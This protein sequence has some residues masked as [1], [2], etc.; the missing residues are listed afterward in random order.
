MKNNFLKPFNNFYS[1]HNVVVRANGAVASWQKRQRTAALQNLAVKILW[2]AVLLAT[3][4]VRAGQTIS[5]VATNGGKTFDG[6]G[7]VSGGGATSVLLT[8]PTP[9]KVLPPLVAMM[10]MV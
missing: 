6:V 1:Q 9:S 2:A 8:A 7:G 3:A 4:S 10:E 5:I